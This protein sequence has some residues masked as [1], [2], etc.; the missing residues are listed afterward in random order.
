M[1][2]DISPLID[3]SIAV[4]PGDTRY[5]RTVNLDMNAGGNLTLSDIRTTVHVGAHTDAPSHYSQA[6]QDIASRS[7]HYYVG[8]CTVLHLDGVRGR[9]IVPDDL[10]GKRIMAARYHAVRR[11]CETAP[12]V[13]SVRL[14]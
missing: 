6:G 5:A 8:P 4:W 14:R 10:K 9:R 2:I 12:V 11:P 13:R 7:L 3:E 1:I